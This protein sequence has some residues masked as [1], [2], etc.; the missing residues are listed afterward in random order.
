MTG[1]FHDRC[2]SGLVSE[3][4]GSLEYIEVAHRMW[5]TRNYERVDKHFSWMTRF[6]VTMSVVIAETP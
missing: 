4:S 1:R 6:L 3:A 2:V 5:R